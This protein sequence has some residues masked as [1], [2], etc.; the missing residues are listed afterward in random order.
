MKITP[1][2]L[3]QRA[4][5]PL[6]N[7]LHLDLTHLGIGAVEGLSYCP[8]LQSLDLSYN[9]L[10]EFENFESCVN[11][12]KL[13]LS[14]NKIKCLS[15]LPQMF[16]I[17]TLDLSNNLLT[18][19]E[20]SHLRS[21]HILD[22]K[23][24]GNSVLSSDTYYRLHVIDCLPNVWMLDGRLVTTA[25]RL[26]VHHF[27]HDSALS[28]HPVRRKLTE[29]TI[30]STKSNDGSIYGCRTYEF[31]ASFSV[32]EH[33]T[34]ETDKRRLAFLAQQFTKDLCIVNRRMEKVLEQLPGNW[35]H[36]IIV[37]RHS[38]T[39][40]CNMLLLL[41]VSYLEFDL[42]FE[43]VAQT[44]SVSK[45]N[46]LFGIDTDLLF[47][48]DSQST[49][50]VVSLLV[51]ACKLDREILRTDKNKGKFG[52]L[53]DKLY[54]CLYHA[55]AHL[56]VTKDKQRNINTRAFKQNPTRS[57]YRL[58][59]PHTAP[60]SYKNNKTLNNVSKTDHRAL[61]EWKTHQCLLASE[62]VLLLSVVPSFYHYISANHTGICKVLFIATGDAKLASHLSLIAEQLAVNGGDVSILYK[63]ICKSVM[64]RIESA[65]KGQTSNLSIPKCDN[66]TSPL[67]SQQC[68]KTE[69][70]KYILNTANAFPK[71]PKSAILASGE[72][73]TSGRS[74][75]VSRSNSTLHRTTPTLS[76]GS[77]VLLGAQNLARVIALPDQNVA[78]VQM[79]AVPASN[80]SVVIHSSNADAHYSY[81][82][83]E[84]L[85]YDLYARYWKPVGSVGDKV[86]LQIKSPSTGVISD[87]QKSNVQSGQKEKKPN[88]ETALTLYDE[89]K[90][91]GEGV[92]EGL[93]L[94]KPLST[95]F[96]E[97]MQV[98]ITDAI[99]QS[100]IQ[101]PDL[102]KKFSLIPGNDVSTFLTQTHACDSYRENE[103]NGLVKNDSRDRDMTKYEP[104]DENLVKNY[105]RELDGIKFKPHDEN[106]VKNDSC[107]LDE[108]KYEPHDENFVKNDSREMEGMKH[109]P[110]DEN[111][112]KNDSRELDELKYEPQDSVK[113]MLNNQDGTEENSEPDKRQQV[114][115]IPITVPQTNVENVAEEE[116]L[117]PNINKVDSIQHGVT[118]DDG[119]LL[120][121][122]PPTPTDQGKLEA[123]KVQQ[124][125]S[126][127]RAHSARVR[128]IPISNEV[129]RKSR[130]SS[131]MISRQKQVMFHENVDH[132]EFESRPGSASSFQL[133]RT[134]AWRS[135]ASSGSGF[136][137]APENSLHEL[138]VDKISNKVKLGKGIKIPPQ[139]PTSPDHPHIDIV[140]IKRLSKE[141][142]L[143][144]ASYS[145]KSPIS[146]G[147]KIKGRLLSTSRWLAEGRNVHKE[148]EEIK[149]CFTSPRLPGYL[150]GSNM[151]PTNT[152]S[153]STRQS[154]PFHHLLSSYQRNNRNQSVS[155][156]SLGGALVWH[157]PQFSALGE[158]RKLSAKSNL[159]RK[160]QARPFLH[161]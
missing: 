99:E 140:Q 72:H 45:L 46:P 79:D 20:L 113:E 114:V 15:S 50:E 77:D 137:I 19:N 96:C 8:K 14:N 111:F 97:K 40:R 86:T 155:S 41:L 152:G 93:N 34:S 130:P 145:I 70:G 37:N 112:V 158:L 80:G 9:C 109:E 131:A 85:E 149:K 76:L 105:S 121:S 57:N 61:V 16:A 73:L 49:I 55:V 147:P 87:N 60:P 160:R 127:R 48:L 156:S 104:H 161:K 6:L 83:T 7:V 51:S 54:L 148:K 12:W 35:L 153:T 25:E 52:G 63:E 108:L 103:K 5:K 78:L 58:A 154:K 118:H 94:Q 24:H 71:R 136:G 116:S 38:Q 115:S 33:Q 102:R 157:R 100:G 1:K 66:W 64:Y 125:L 3:L 128:K 26:Q 91:V 10:E 2:I 138:I 106:L 62:L 65:V 90:L 17:G 133:R 75:I 29:K 119:N 141:K 95:V 139:R 13:N 11:L 89:N 135:S 21:I 142:L 53:Y 126:H 23:L 129:A 56:I 68:E 18:W 22:L 150:V 82:D 107:E 81:I 44:L 151:F 143:S 59:R 39:E 43:L 144:P 32:S 69:Q 122:N 30:L 92:Y 159:P 4:Q 74:R 42:P 36:H 117:Q 120:Y 146:G 134:E 47:K 123:T 67:L 27:F 88:V 98:N 84:K 101:N 28:R 124:H 110:H 31:T 132:C